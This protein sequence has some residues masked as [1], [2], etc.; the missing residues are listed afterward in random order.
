[1]SRGKARSSHQSS[2]TRTPP[3]DAGKLGQVDRPPQEPG[4]QPGEPVAADLRQ[5][6]CGGRAPPGC[7]G[8]GSGTVR[9]RSA[10]E[11]GG[12]VVRRPS[13]P[14]AC[15][16]WAV[17]GQGRAVGGRG[18]ARSRR[19]PRRRRARP[20]A[21]SGR[22]R[23]T[24]R[25][26]ARRAAPRR[27]DSGRLPAVHTKRRRRDRSPSL[28][29][30]AVGT[31]LGDP[32]AEPELDPP[33]AQLRPARTRRAR[34]TVPAGCARR[35]ARGRSA[36]HRRATPGYWCSTPCTRSNSSATSLRPGESAAGD[37]EGQQLA[38]AGRGRI[39]WSARS[40]SAEHVVAQ[41]GR[42]AE[43]LQREGVLGQAGRSK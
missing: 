37:D 14:R 22:R 1:M 11:R 23:R 16:C 33:A 26:R 13:C 24:R 28:S 42:V 30:T 38:L 34:R 10:G 20:P 9:G 8:C 43:R 7:R 35:R 18:C 3:L 17:G 19:S 32:Y 36:A 40:S 5:R 4:E 2:R 15:A 21:A 25:C 6:R 27:A 41:A 39:S 12:D 29:R 31:R